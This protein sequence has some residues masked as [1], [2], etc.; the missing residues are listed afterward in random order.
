MSSIKVTALVELEVNRSKAP[1]ELNIGDH[2]FLTRKYVESQ[3]RNAFPEELD[4]E[5]M[6]L[7]P[8]HLEIHHFD[9]RQIVLNL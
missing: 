7:M 4:I 5:F 8:S 1:K 6:E 9:D 2:I 3:L